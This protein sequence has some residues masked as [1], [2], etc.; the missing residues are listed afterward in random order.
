MGLSVGVG[1][2]EEI[3]E[4]FNAGREAA[5]MAL[6]QLGA[7]KGDVIM[8]FT[9]VDYNHPEL[10]KGIRSV[11]GDTPL[12][13]CTTDGEITTYGTHE[14][15]VS[16]VI[17]KSD[18]VKFSFGVGQD[19]SSDYD[20]AVQ[21]AVDQVTTGLGSA[22]KVIIAFP[23]TSMIG[24]GVEMLNA[25]QQKVGKECL[26]V[27]GAP[28]D[29]ERLK[30][31]FQFYND[32]V[33]TNSVCLLGLAGPFSIGVGAKSGLTALGRVAQVTKSDRNVI[34]EID[35]KPAI[36]YH[37]D[38]VGSELTVPATIAN[39]PFILV[40]ETLKTDVDKFFATRAAF[41]YNEENGAVICGASIPEGSTVRLGRINRDSIFAGARDAAQEALRLLAGEKPQVVFCFSCSGRK[42]I[43]GLELPKEMQVVQEVVGKDVPVIGF[44]SYA[45]LGP[46]KFDDERLSRCEYQ[47]Y[48][49]SI[50]ALK[51]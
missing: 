27:G 37:R 29:S 25:L 31:T 3:E 48:T 22:A 17:L 35:G 45:E 40:N 2:S 12:I 33:L 47:S 6:K 39:F 38:Y 23:D 51:A 4:P 15:S 21:T 36:Q 42:Q 16:L 43:L 26:V 49:M 50:F 5:E 18:S 1:Y 7:A 30:Q 44:Y 34:L 41:F 10:L 14:D 9:S 28:G 24:C 20:K 8:M 13:G 46:V 32:T 11:T 19:L